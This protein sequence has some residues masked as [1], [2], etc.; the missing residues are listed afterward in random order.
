MVIWQNCDKLIKTAPPKRWAR[1]RPTED[2]KIFI[3]CPRL[4]PRSRI[5]NYQH[6]HR[7]INREKDKDCMAMG[8][9]CVASLEWVW[10][11][12][13]SGFTFSALLE[14]VW[15][16]GVTTSACACAWIKRYHTQHNAPAA[17]PFSASSPVKKV[18]DSLFCNYSLL[19]FCVA[20]PQ[21]PNAKNL[22][23]FTVY[24]C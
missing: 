21:Y 2:I 19:N 11:V 6:R 17:K 12:L 24:F 5:P 20:A 1:Y 16:R 4:A 14:R 10:Y 23:L 18:L 7:A 8:A 3:Y 15:W 9:S 22:K 13:A